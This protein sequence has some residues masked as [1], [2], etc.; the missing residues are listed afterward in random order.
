VRQE[1]ASHFHGRIEIWRHF[2]DGR[3]VR[4]EV[5]SKGKGL[6]DTVYHH[7]NKKMVREER[8]DNGN[9]NVSFP[10]AL[11]KWPPRQNRGGHQWPAKSINGSILTQAKTARSF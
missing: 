5:D 7:E 2:K 6:A 10:R 8:D 9:G 11:S 4:R 1:A 3:L